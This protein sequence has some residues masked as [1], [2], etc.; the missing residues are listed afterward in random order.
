VLLQFTGGPWGVAAAHGDCLWRQGAGKG[1]V[2]AER[3][4]VQRSEQHAF[5]PP[6]LRLERELVKFSQTSSVVT[7]HSS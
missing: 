5:A 7:L 1:D 2:P 6:V 4:L 3:L